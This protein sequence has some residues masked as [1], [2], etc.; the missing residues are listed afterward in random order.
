MIKIMVDS[1]A[2]C[3]G[4]FDVQ[5]P[6]NVRLNGREYQD[7]VD[8]TADQFYSLLAQAP[9]FPQTSQPSPETFAAEFEKAKAAGDEILC[10]TLSSALSGT[11]QSAVIARELA[12]YDGIYVI[13]TRTVTHT[14]G[15]LAKLAQD[16]A[17]Q[18]LPAE[19]IARCCE[20]LKHR[21]K[22]LA[23]LD[24]LE[25]LYKGGRL[26]KASAAVGQLAGIKPVV[27]VTPEGS[28]GMAG[29][30]IGAPRAMQLILSKLQALELDPAFPM[31]SLYSQGTENTQ[32]L[33]NKLTQAGYTL[34][35]RKQVGPTIG[36]HVGPGIYGVIFVIK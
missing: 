16:L 9:E 17:A 24:T 3:G 34:Q 2:D 11:Y 18:G 29:K 26:S 6:L 30:A 19:E 12:D 1:A 4:M 36:A 31:Y 7:G 22:V 27:T 33:E 15:F 10:F 28:V 25:Y 35:G 8:L 32:L 13:D 20:E 21:I 14:I 23:G 5:I